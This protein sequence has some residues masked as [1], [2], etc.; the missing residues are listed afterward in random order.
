MV[1]WL[2]IHLAM[3]ETLVQS[4]IWG[5]STCCGAAKPVHDNYRARESWNPH[6]MTKE[7]TAMRSPLVTTR[8]KSLLTATRESPRAAAKTQNSKKK[9]R[10]LKRAIYK[11]KYSLLYHLFL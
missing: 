8:E 2:R 5:D 9:K 11:W 6:S 10:K 4:L 1:Q 3:P 7:A